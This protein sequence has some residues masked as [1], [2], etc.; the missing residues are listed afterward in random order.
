MFHT[1]V[2]NRSNVFEILLIFHVYVFSVLCEFV[3]TSRL[4]N[5]LPLL[6]V[7]QYRNMYVNDLFY[8]FYNLGINMYYIVLCHITQHTGL[9]NLYDQYLTKK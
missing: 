4:L 7:L 5:L 3:Y 6:H 2:V 1:F 8:L 9:I